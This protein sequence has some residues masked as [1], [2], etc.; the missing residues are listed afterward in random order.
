MRERAVMD[1]N[2]VLVA[3]KTLVSAVSW[4]HSLCSSNFMLL[5]YWLSLED[6][7]RMITS[8]CLCKS[9]TLDVWFFMEHQGTRLSPWKRS[10]FWMI[11][12]GGVVVVIIGCTFRSLRKTLDCFPVLQQTLYAEYLK[13]SVADQDLWRI[14][15][16]PIV[17]PGLPSPP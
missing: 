9:K 4:I 12:R 5:L 8:C 13:Q 1:G 14:P 6:M 3:V 7:T 16:F 2:I 17:S 10:S 11:L 15:S